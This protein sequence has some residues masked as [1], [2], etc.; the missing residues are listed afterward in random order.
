MFSN[1]SLSESLVEVSPSDLIHRNSSLNWQVHQQTSHYCFTVMSGH[2]KIRESFPFYCV[3]FLELVILKSETQGGEDI[4]RSLSSQNETFNS[5]CFSKFGES[6]KGSR[7]GDE[8]G[9]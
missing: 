7:S 4:C 5:T 2:W 1:S 8:R 3:V 6:E 9:E